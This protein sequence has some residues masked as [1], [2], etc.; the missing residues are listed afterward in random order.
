MVPHT[1]AP[2]Q[3]DGQG[4]ARA[5]VPMQTRKPGYSP[6]FPF[7]LKP[8]AACPEPDAAAALV[9][10]HLAEIPMSTSR[11]WPGSA[12]AML[13]LM[14]GL[15]ADALAD[16]LAAAVGAL[17]FRLGRQLNDVPERTHSP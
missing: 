14:L 1:C 3:P 12:C 5:L 15:T 16:D 11:C 17:F 6:G 4:C 7:V 13:A 8:S 9:L 10:Q 2:G